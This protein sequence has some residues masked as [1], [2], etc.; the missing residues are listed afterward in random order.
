MDPNH[1]NSWLNLGEAY[2]AISSPDKALDAYLEAW[3]RDPE[4]ATTLLV[5]ELRDIGDFD[6]LEEVLQQSLNKYPNSKMRLTW[7][8][9]LGDYYSMRRSG[10]T[11]TAAFYSGSEPVKDPALVPWEETQKKLDD[12][13]KWQAKDK[14]EEKS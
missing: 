1:A 13:D 6:M 12:I 14:E 9:A 10:G 5:S 7:M 11:G 2:K 3:S 4:L 8:Q